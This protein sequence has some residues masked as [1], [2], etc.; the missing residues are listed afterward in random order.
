MFNLKLLNYVFKLI[1][2]YC[3]ELSFEKRWDS[4]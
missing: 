1:L 4:F 3:L 2:F